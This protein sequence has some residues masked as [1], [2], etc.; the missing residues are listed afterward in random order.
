[1]QEGSPAKG[2]RKDSEDGGSVSVLFRKQKSSK[3]QTG[4]R[5]DVLGCPGSWGRGRV[6]HFTR[7]RELNKRD[8]QDQSE[9][10]R[11]RHTQ[12]VGTTWKTGEKKNTSEVTHDWK[13]RIS[14]KK[15]G[16]WFRIT[17]AEREVALLPLGGQLGSN[18]DL[19]GE[20]GA[21][22][23]SNQAKK[24]PFK[25]GRRKIQGFWGIGSKEKDLTRGKKREKIGD[26]GVKF[27]A[28]KGIRRKKRRK[29]RRSK[30]DG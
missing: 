27:V 11:G 28:Y 18:Y 16:P 20:R 23:E 21:E 29:G 7:R 6:C 17:T 4:G 3:I 10:M 9:R 2:K 19:F 25:D 30:C 26:S 12:R 15:K 14:G 24:G 13:R 22:R 8:A 5:G 1:L